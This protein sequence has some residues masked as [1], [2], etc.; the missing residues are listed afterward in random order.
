[1]APSTDRIAM[2]ELDTYVMPATPEAFAVA[3]PTPEVTTHTHEA[4]GSAFGGAGA[5]SARASGKV[6]TARDL[7]GP[8]DLAWRPELVA[9]VTADGVPLADVGRAVVR[10]DTR[11]PLGVVGSR[12]VTFDHSH[13]FDLAD[14]IAGAAGG[15][16][17]FGNAGHKRGGALPFLQLE[18]ETDSPVGNVKRMI[19]L[20]TSHDGSLCYTAGFSDVV[21]VCRNTYAHALGDARNGLKIRHT[22]S[23]A[24]LL[25]NVDAIAAASCDHA[26]KWDDRALR[27]LSTPFSDTQAVA[28]ASHLCPGEGKRAENSRKALLDAYA[29]A[30]GARPGTAWGAAQAVTHYTSHTVGTEEARAVTAVTGQGTGAD[31]QASA[32]WALDTTPDVMAARLQTVALFRV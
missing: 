11:A 23:G 8:A 6:S 14:A 20:F 18:C 10:S 19:S 4:N 31:L 27:M 13:M 24:E 12:Y 28:L 2:I 17:R 1:M 30:P 16:L 5:L 9:I 7:V 22:A 32:W 15:A 29:S 21:I 26:A 25:A 3:L